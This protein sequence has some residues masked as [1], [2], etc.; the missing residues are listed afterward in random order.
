[1]TGE[2]GR[3]G[4]IL[5]YWHA[6]EMFDP[7]GIPAAPDPRR[8]TRKPTRPTQSRDDLTLNSTGERAED[9]VEAIKIGRGDPIPPLPWEPGHELFG[10]QPPP[11]KFG[12]EWRHVIYGGVF[13]YEKVREAFGHVLG[14]SENPDHGGRRKEIDSALFAFTVDQDGVLMGDTVVL[15]SCGWATGRLHHPGPDVPGWLDGFEEVTAACQR[16]MRALL[17]KPVRYEREAPRARQGQLADP[18][19]RRGWRAV[20]AEILGGAAVGAVNAVLGGAAA[21]VGGPVGAGA[22]GGA[23]DAILARVTNRAK[24]ETAPPVGE[25]PPADPREEQEGGTGAEPEPDGRAVQVLDVVAVTAQLAVALRLPE[26]LVRHLM[27]TIELRVVTKVAYCRRDGSVNEPEPAILA[28]MIAPDILKVRDAIPKGLG[29]A[30]ASYLSPPLDGGQRIDLAADRAHLLAGLR[31]ERFPLGRWPADVDRP[32]AAGQQF[33]VNTIL[34]DLDGGRGRDPQAAL[35]AGGGLLAVNGPPGTG[36]TTM[37]RDLIAEIVVRRAQALATLES[38]S[39][40]FPKSRKRTWRPDD[41]KERSVW[42]PRADL[43]GFEIVV[44]SSNNG[45]VENITR[46]LPAVTALGEAWRG[47]ADETPEAAPETVPDYFAAQASAYLGEPAWGVIAAPLGNSKKRK[48]FLG[49]FWFADDGAGGMR[50]RLQELE[51]DRPSPADWQ[52]AV[53][54]FTDAYDHAEAMARERSAA[55]DGLRSPL[56]CQWVTQAQQAADDAAAAA[57]D[58]GQKAREA[59]GKVTGHWHAAEAV[60]KLQAD[61]EHARPRGLKGVLGGGKTDWRTDAGRLA[62]RLASH[63]ENLAAAAI[64][65][66]EARQIAKATGTSAAEAKQEAERYAARYQWQQA[67]LETARRS[68]GGRF[69]EGWLGL[70]Q[71]EQEMSA[72]WSDEQWTRA[73]T[74]VFLAAADLHRAFVAGAAWQFSHNLT[75]LTALLS[76]TPGAPQGEAALGAWQTLFLLV[77]VISTTFASCGRLLK[78]LGREPL[79]WLLIDEAGQAL[80]Q[81]ATGALWRTRRAVVVGD[82]LQLEPISQVPDEIQARLRH[83]Y[84]V[85][86]RWQPSGTSAQGLADRRTR[87]GTQIPRD[88]GDPVWV[89]APLRVHR[90]CEEPMFSVSNEIAYHGLMVHATRKEPFPGGG[91]KDYPGSGWIDVAG[92]ADPRDPRDSKWRPD[93]G[94]YLMR[95]LRR[96]HDENGVGLDEIFVISPFRDVALKCRALVRG[97]RVTHLGQGQDQGSLFEGGRPTGGKAVITATQDE[98]EAFAKDHVGTVHTMQGKEA[99]VVILILGTGHSGGARDWAADQVNLLNVAVSRAR[100]RLFVIGGHDEWATAG[101]F[102]ALSKRLP[103]WHEPPSS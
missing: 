69:P 7:Q 76:R 29:V 78:P 16:T 67:A 62:A 84:Q 96:L 65:A 42:Q 89:G 23:L 32:L 41:A 72:P 63:E 9:R 12:S 97:R 91:R 54:R 34:A 27:S 2:T 5:S 68:W 102:A 95:V 71:D 55:D 35:R 77:P 30:L 87:W 86:H 94:E 48:E 4:D 14:Y 64:A 51:R 100:R 11:G 1:M 81:A 52:K 58:A 24:G 101:N 56:P 46:E 59:E 45:A 6:V 44:A 99:D 26:N 61:H 22:L 10:V 15:S 57:R 103:A 92:Q 82:P 19:G 20:L 36:K 53:R 73:R 31:P 40:G 33:A 18:G 43:A 79:G 37:L 49:K 21:V 80:P 88:E 66:K 17:S 93:Q 85:D 60:R 39:E 38:P 83:Q 75:H 98:I 47:T 3:A 50:A 8:P 90:R 25:Q 70:P 13:S 74:E 28:S